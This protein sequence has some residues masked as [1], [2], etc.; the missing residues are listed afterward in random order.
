MNIEDKARKAAV[1]ARQQAE[2]LE[3]T[4]L[5]RAEEAIEEYTDE[6]L[7]AEARELAARKRQQAKET[8]ER[9]LGRSEEEIGRE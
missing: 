1:Q 7:S 6:S 3:E 9:L 2:H 8:K 5:H 4:I